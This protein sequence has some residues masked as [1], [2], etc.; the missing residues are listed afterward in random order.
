M[1][2]M[3]LISGK[4]TYI[5]AVLTI[6]YAVTAYFTGNMDLNTATQMVLGGA[7]LGALRAGVTKS[8]TSP[9]P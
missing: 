1:D 6:I 8:A 2:I 7:G 3:N 4:K 9:A 5:V